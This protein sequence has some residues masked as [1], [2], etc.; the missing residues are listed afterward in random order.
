[1]DKTLRESGRVLTVLLSGIVML[2]STTVK[3]NKMLHYKA[4]SMKI[5]H[6]LPIYNL[7]QIA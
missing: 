3:A 2:L 1:M 5:Y 6:V 4:C 7:R